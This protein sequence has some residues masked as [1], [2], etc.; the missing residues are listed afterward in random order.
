[1][2]PIS[3]SQKKKIPYYLFLKVPKTQ[4]V[5]EVLPNCHS[6]FEIRII[7]PFPF[8]YQIFQNS[9]DIINFTTVYLLVSLK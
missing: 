5:L 9:K 7:P 3:T 6:V 1:M 8:F 2:K 4:A